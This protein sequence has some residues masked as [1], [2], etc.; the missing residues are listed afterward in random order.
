MFQQWH[1]IQTLTEQH[2][3]LI[4]FKLFR[5]LLHLVFTGTRSGLDDFRLLLAGT[6]LGSTYWGEKM[7]QLGVI[8]LL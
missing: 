6:Q 1:L 8:V 2:A 7:K 5:Q 4:T 3:G